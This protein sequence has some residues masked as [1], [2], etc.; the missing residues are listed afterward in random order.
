[1]TI[2]TGLKVC[3]SEFP[4][5]QECR[6]YVDKNDRDR[7]GF[8]TLS[9]CGA[10]GR[11]MLPL[12][13]RWISEFPGRVFVDPIHLSA[14]A[15]GQDDLE[16]MNEDNLIRE[17]LPEARADVCWRGCLVLGDQSTDAMIFNPVKFDRLPRSESLFVLARVTEEQ[18]A[19][20]PSSTN[21]AVHCV[22]RVPAV[23]PDLT[24]TVLI[25]P[26]EN[27]C[28]L[29]LMTQAP[30]H[31]YAP[32]L[33]GTEKEFLLRPIPAPSLFRDIHKAAIDDIT[34]T[35]HLQ[36]PHYLRALGMGTER[37][38]RTHADT[39]ETIMTRKQL[40]VMRTL[41]K[42][43]TKIV[44]F[45]ESYKRTSSEPQGDTNFE[46]GTVMKRMKKLG[47]KA[48]QESINNIFQTL[49]QEAGSLED[50]VYAG[51]RFRR[52]MG[53]SYNSHKW[54]HMPFLFQPV[55][56]PLESEVVGSL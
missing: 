19:S 56:A 13:D 2:T 32:K 37:F 24:N 15:E 39:L 31:K 51:K 14:D 27:D 23:W 35:A 7:K 44:P 10:Q 8:L 28:C 54:V 46:N 25:A 26:Q 17:R 43:E 36:Q 6:E 38:G 53:T 40:N 16:L 49:S 50:H 22:I 9:D 11:Y 33:R 52:L 20:I 41:E 30:K 3:L 45:F 29:F 21:R 1:M 48:S 4:S 18:W 34:R 5:I 42:I 47:A 12:I 55:D